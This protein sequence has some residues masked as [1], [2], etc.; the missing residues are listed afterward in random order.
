MNCIGLPVPN[1]PLFLN[2]RQ[3]YRQ[4]IRF[5]GVKAW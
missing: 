4:V 2:A 3:P 1:R 5:K